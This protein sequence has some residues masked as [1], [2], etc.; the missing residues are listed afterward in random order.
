[1]ERLAKVYQQNKRSIK[2]VVAA[3]F[4]SP[5]FY[6][7]KAYRSHL[8]TPLYFVLSSLRQLNIEA[9]MDRVIGGLRAMG[10][11]PYNAPSVKGW[12]GDS[13]WLTA[14]SLLTRCNIAQQFTKDYGDDGGFNFDPDRYT[15]KELVTVLL[16][17]NPEGNLTNQFQG[18]SQREVAALILATPLYQ[19]A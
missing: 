14:P 13:G 11:V 16:D 4:R 5:E 8:K 10:Q 3:M 9:D 2:A 6:S 7:A 1:V 15:A 19:L 17:G 12:Q 18:L